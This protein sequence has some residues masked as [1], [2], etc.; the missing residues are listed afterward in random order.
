MSFVISRAGELVARTG[1]TYVAL[2]GVFGVPWQT[3]LALHP[4]ADLFAIL[5][6]TTSCAVVAL[7]AWIFRAT[8][9]RSGEA[10]I[11]GFARHSRIFYLPWLLGVGTAIRL[12]WALAFPAAPVSDG[13]IYL[14][15]ARQLAAGEPFRMANSI[16]FWPP[17]Y[18]IFLSVWL[19]LILSERVTLILSNL[20][21][22]E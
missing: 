14:Q 8:L 6:G 22:Q 3:I 18:P 7:I 13:A 2:I 1:L 4:E 20:T 16:A 21:F 11:A 5:A 15:L 9:I 17:G 19:K 12:I 10:A